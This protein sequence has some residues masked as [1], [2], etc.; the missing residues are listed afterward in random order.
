VKCLLIATIAT[1][2]VLAGAAGA[3]AETVAGPLG[4]LSADARVTTAGGEPRLRVEA[5]GAVADAAEPPGGLGPAATLAGWWD[6]R[7]AEA[8]PSDPVALAATPGAR[9]IA[10]DPAGLL[11][12]DAGPYVASAEGR[13]PVR[14]PVRVCTYLAAA[15]G[16]GL[17]VGTVLVAR[18][19][20]A[21]AAPAAAAVSECGRRTAARLLGVGVRA[22]D[23]KWSYDLRPGELAVGS[24]RCLQLVAGGPPEM[25]VRYRWT[26]PV[27]CV[28]ADPWTVFRAG[29]RGWRVA[30]ARIKTGAWP[31]TTIALT[32]G[33]RGIVEPAALYEA[34]DQD[35]CAPSGFARTL[36]QWGGASWVVRTIAPAPGR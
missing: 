14:T 24:V 31:L 20:V 3:G 15:V 35:P 29:A 13:A 16:S 33:R 7:V 25:V 26:R 2:A 22:I 28:T 34:D 4:R 19:V 1:L 11:E 6:G 30:L 18:D 17:P 36:I 23:G 27:T 21:P 8:C 9:A 10:W 32:G 5:T 12:L